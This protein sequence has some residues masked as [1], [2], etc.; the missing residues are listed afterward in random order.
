M[1]VRLCLSSA[2]MSNAEG[3]PSWAWPYW[4]KRNR[5]AWIGAFGAII[6]AIIVILPG[7]LQSDNEKS[8]R[9]ILSIAGDK[10]AYTEYRLKS[11][12]R[13]FSNTTRAEI[14]AFHLK[15]SAD[16]SRL[17]GLIVLGADESPEAFPTD[18]DL[19][20]IELEEFQASPIDPVWQTI[21]DAGRIFQAAST[22]LPSEAINFDNNPSI[23]GMTTLRRLY[24][25]LY[26]SQDIEAWEDFAL[27]A[28]SESK[29]GTDI[30]VRAIITRQ[31]SPVFNLTVVNE[32]NDPVVITQVTIEVGDVAPAA[33]GL[34]SGLLTPVEEIVFELKR[35]TERL[36]EPLSAPSLIAAKESASVSVKLNSNEMFSYLLKFHLGSGDETVLSTD[37]TI[38]DFGFQPQSQLIKR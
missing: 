32:G 24:L 26:T 4:P 36:S 12:P 25:D 30:S 29:A 17:L 27:A 6:A 5:A 18:Q 21:L 20:P 8:A 38:V 9:L 23:A 16:I 22:P 2:Q 14:R 1:P 7:L 15:P 34:K 35:D 33:S 3:K 37:W 19:S 10:S 28:L 11:A 13:P 31:L